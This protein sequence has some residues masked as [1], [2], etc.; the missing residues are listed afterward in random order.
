MWQNI[1][2]RSFGSNHVLFGGMIPPAS[3]IAIKSSIL[4]GNIE[5][6]HA[7]SPLSTSFS[8]SAVPR[9]P[10]QNEF[11]CSCAG[12]QC[13][14]LAQGRVFVTTSHPIFQLGRLLP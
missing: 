5:N 1:A 13:Q 9:I 11:F 14:K 12:H 3:A 7:N 2:S 10:R 6:A 8:N 4:V